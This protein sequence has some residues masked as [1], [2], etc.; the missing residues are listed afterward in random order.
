MYFVLTLVAMNYLTVISS[1]YQAYLLADEAH[2]PATCPPSA[3]HV[4]G[5]KEYIAPA[6]ETS[7]FWHLLWADT[8]RP[9]NGIIA[10]IMQHTR[11]LYHKSINREDIVN[12]RLP[13]AIAQNCN[14]DFW[15]EVKNIHKNKLS[16]R[17]KVDDLSS[18]AEI[19]DLFASKY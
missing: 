7:L 12:E 19:A 11:T 8:D 4:L 9:R 17:S 15:R 18:P 10:D 5:W 3:D 16:L 2:I 1:I 14:R 6:R 13:T